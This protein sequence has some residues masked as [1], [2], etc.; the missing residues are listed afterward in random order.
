MSQSSDRTRRSRRIGF[1]LVELL[2]V[3]AIIGVLVALLLPA[4]Q[5]ARE[6]AR[7]MQCSN[8]LKQIAL[9]AHHF[10]NVYQ[11]LPPGYNG[12]VT[13]DRSRPSYTQWTDAATIWSVPWLGVHAYLLPYMEQQALSD[14]ILAE[15]NPDKY[16]RA[17][18]MNITMVTSTDSNDEARELLRG[19]GMPFRAAGQ[20]AVEAATFDVLHHEIVVSA[21]FADVDGLN[22]VVVVELSGGAAF[23]VKALHE[24]RILAQTAGQDLHRDDAVEADLLGP[25]NHGHRPGPALV[26]QLVPRNLLRRLATRVIID[27]LQPVELGPSQETEVD[28]DFAHRPATA[29]GEDFLVVVNGRTNFVRRH[30]LTLDDRFENLTVFGGVGHGLLYDYA[31]ARRQLPPQFSSNSTQNNRRIQTIGARGTAGSRCTRPGR[32]RKRLAAWVRICDSVD[33]RLFSLAAVLGSCRRSTKVSF[34]HVHFG[35]LTP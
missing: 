8:H 10:H 22:D 11:H 32:P 25:I 35:T 27:P 13:D 20:D 24:L 33:Q 9:A 29:P 4:V 15:L 2:V 14:R 19:F 30:Q 17:Q 26:Q 5:A 12:I 16:S 7:R 31:S 28:E 34:P 1:T 18:G 6:A 21:G 23:A 3:I